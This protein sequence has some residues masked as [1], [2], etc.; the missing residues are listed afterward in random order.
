MRR[1]PVL[2]F[3]SRPGAYPAVPSPRRAVRR[4]KLQA[5]RKDAQDLTIECTWRATGASWLHRCRLHRFYGDF[6]SPWAINSSASFITRTA[7][8][9]SGHHPVA[10]GKERIVL[11]DSSKY[12]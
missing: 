6:F 12:C 8:I 3:R 7:I 2:T 11:A 9:Q 1:D 4:G 5:C 10:G